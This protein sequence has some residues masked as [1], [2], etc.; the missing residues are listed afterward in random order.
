VP[1]EKIRSSLAGHDGLVTGAAFLRGDDTKVATGSHD[2]TVRIYD[3]PRSLCLKTVETRS[4]VNAVLAGTFG[5][6]TAHQ[7]GTICRWD[8]RSGSLLA[9]SAAI[10]TRAIVS[11]V[12]LPETNEIITVSLDHSIK[13]VDLGT[14]A[15]TQTLKH[16][17]FRVPAEG[18]LPSLSPD[19]K[20]IA[21]GS[22][23][24]SLFIF[25]RAWNSHVETILDG[26]KSAIVATAW[27]EKSG[28]LVSADR[29]GCIKIWK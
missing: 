13:S 14:L 26:H 16:E 10:H 9:S 19:N 21:V 20:F 18:G 17:S 24:G 3:L 23:S 6:L 12:H 27:S 29:T 8:E 7:D 4:A 25:N 28:L 11:A 22:S 15:V 5:I 1:S 2:H